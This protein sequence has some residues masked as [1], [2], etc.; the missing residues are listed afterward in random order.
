MGGLRMNKA[1]TR[2]NWENEPAVTTPLNATNLNKIDGAVN[3]LDD[4]IIVLDTNFLE[5]YNQMNVAQSYTP[6]ASNL[7]TITTHLAMKKGGIGRYRLNANSGNW[8]GGTIY[9]LTTL[10]PAYRPSVRIEKEIVLRNGCQCYFLI[11]TSGIVDIAPRTSINNLNIL[12]DET[13]MI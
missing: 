8:I 9:S 2:I 6:I 10:S 4:R 11:N 12:I 1:Y 5:L 7:G 13:Y 3:I